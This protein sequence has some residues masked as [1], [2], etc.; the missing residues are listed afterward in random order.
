MQLKRSAKYSGKSIIYTTAIQQN[1]SVFNSLH[2]VHLV[3]FSL[4]LQPH[5]PNFVYFTPKFRLIMIYDQPLAANTFCK[6]HQGYLSLGLKMSLSCIMGSVGEKK[7][8]CYKCSN[9]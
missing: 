4:M 5:L 2:K 7:K 8:V 9:F 3:Q 6:C 1:T